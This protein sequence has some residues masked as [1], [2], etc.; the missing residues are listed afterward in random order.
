MIIFVRFRWNSPPRPSSCVSSAPRGRH[1]RRRG[2][3][4]SEDTSAK[5]PLPWRGLR[6]GGV[7]GNTSTRDAALSL[8]PVEYLCVCVCL[9][10]R[11]W[12]RQQVQIESAWFASSRRANSGGRRLVPPPRPP[13]ETIRASRPGVWPRRRVRDR[14]QLPDTCPVCSRSRETSGRLLAG[15][16][17]WRRHVGVSPIR[18][19]DGHPS[20]WPRDQFRPANG[21]GPARH[22]QS[23]TLGGGGSCGKTLASNDDDGL[24]RLVWSGLVARCR[25]P[26]R[27]ITR[28]PP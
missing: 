1:R 23:R 17:R 25:Q 20:I 12:S 14:H 28:R 16:Q 18:R 7:A 4:V 27:P 22:T 24:R 9:L 8:T 13:D 21:T 11:L 10:S 15:T 5:R 6:I 19:P 2:R 3:S 26:I